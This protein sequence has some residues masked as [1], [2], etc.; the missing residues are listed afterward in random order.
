MRTSRVLGEGSSCYHVMTRVI[1]RRYL[2]DDEEKERLLRIL[3]K[4]EAF[5]GVR[6][7]TFCVMSNH[8]HLLLE[9][10]A[11]ETVVDPEVLRRVEGLYGR[12]YAAGLRMRVEQLR[13][14]GD[15]AG[16]ER[17]LEPYRRRMNDLSV[18]V[19]EVLQRFTQ[20][21]NR[22]HN[23]RGTLWEDRFKSV[24]VEG[25]GQALAM[26][27][28]Y[29]DLNPVRAGIVSDPKD[30]RYCGYAQAV[31]G[32]LLARRGLMRVLGSL[33]QEEPA[34]GRD[35]LRAVA[36]IM[37][38]LTGWDHQA[39]ELEINALIAL[40]ASAGLNGHDVRCARDTTICND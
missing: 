2:L 7:V 23:R 37:A 12:E 24:L 10:L 36:Q 34:Q 20:Q 14:D 21:Y 35:T 16:V 1:E 29:I 11:G 9:V 13:A 40:E 19:K 33:G 4:L 32:G 27:A 15:G 39:Q 25:G 30:Y 22:R 38:P 5:C 28:A 18:F 31:A 6:V 3:R 26:M 17:V 8:L